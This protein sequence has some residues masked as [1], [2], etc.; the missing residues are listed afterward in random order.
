[1]SQDDLVLAHLECGNTITPLE[2]LQL[3]GTLA[4][5]S[6][7]ARLRKRGYAIDKTMRSANGKRFG[8]YWLA[9]AH[10]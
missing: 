5:H 6:C 7:I 2:A 4:L 8:E 3:A 1:M 9:V 10:G